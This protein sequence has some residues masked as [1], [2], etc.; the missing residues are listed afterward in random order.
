MSDLV[1]QRIHVITDEFIDR[2]MAEWIGFVVTVCV[3]LLQFDGVDVCPGE[4]WRKSLLVRV[5]PS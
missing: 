5:E 2:G 4:L 1:R 3:L